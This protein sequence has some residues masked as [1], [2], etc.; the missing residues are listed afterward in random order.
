MKVQPKKD[1]KLMEQVSAQKRKAGEARQSGA[2]IWTGRII[3]LLVILFLV[4]DG[5]TKVMQ[6]RHVLAAAA[7]LG[8]SAAAMVWIGAVLVA[9]TAVYAMPRTSVLGAI[10]LTGYLGGAVAIQA[11]AG[12]PVFQCA[13]PVIFCVLVWLGLFMR[14]PRL[15]TI[16]PLREN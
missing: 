10:L 6:E 7:Q 13:F 5:A 12:N 8:Y 3:S 11:H 1:N 15:R 16:I 4:F 2:A 9:C 14:D